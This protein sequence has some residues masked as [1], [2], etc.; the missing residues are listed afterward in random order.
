MVKV[1][2]QCAIVGQVGDSFEVEIDAD[3]LVADLKE[4]VKA[5][6]DAIITVPY[7]KLQLFLA[8]KGAGWLPS[9]ELAALLAEAPVGFEKVPL[10]DPAWSIHDVLEEMKMP[11]P[12]TRQIHV[13]VVV[14]T[15]PTSTVVPIRDQENVDTEVTAELEYTN[16]EDV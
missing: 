6:N 1:S 10:T 12:G 7:P 13:L 16:D 5:G 15:G 8:K 2:I 14:P 4:R 9:S 11:N 3:Q